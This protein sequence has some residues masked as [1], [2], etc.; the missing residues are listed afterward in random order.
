M[1]MSVIKLDQPNTAAVQQDMDNATARAYLSSTD[2]YIIR[3]Q[4]TGVAIPL[5]VSEARQIARD[6][7]KDSE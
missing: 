3:L 1:A 2:W 6:S 7:I 4:E 5:E